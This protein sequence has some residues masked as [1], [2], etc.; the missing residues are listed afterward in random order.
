MGAPQKISHHR[1]CRTIENTTEAK[2]AQPMRNHPTIGSV[3]AE[4]P[5]NPTLPHS[6]EVDGGS[7]SEASPVVK[8]TASHE[9]RRISPESR[10][11][12]P[13]P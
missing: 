7:A 2:T 9:S 11:D 8:V 13:E 6:P 1:R 5:N 10:S 3:W 12:H 4:T